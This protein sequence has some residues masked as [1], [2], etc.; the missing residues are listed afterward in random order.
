MKKL[1]KLEKF[2][3]INKKL[4]TVLGGQGAP[5]KSFLKLDNGTQTGAGEGCII[6]GQCSTY[7]SDV[8]YDNGGFVYSGVKFIDK[9]C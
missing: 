3:L 5:V 7:T 6:N 8:F 4:E 1:E 9:P 2:Q